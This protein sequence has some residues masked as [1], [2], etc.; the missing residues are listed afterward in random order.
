MVQSTIYEDD[1]SRMPQYGLAMAIS[2]PLI[3]VGIRYSLTIDLWLPK[4]LAGTLITIL[5]SVVIVLID[6]QSILKADADHTT[7]Q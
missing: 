1:K 4:L 5:S 6:Y 2:F 7:S 3:I